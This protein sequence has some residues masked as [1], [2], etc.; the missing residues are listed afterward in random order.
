L[1]GSVAGSIV[2]VGLATHQNHFS[3]LGLNETRAEFCDEFGIERVR[4]I[5]TH[6]IGKAERCAFLVIEYNRPSLRV[7]KCLN[8]VI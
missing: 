8:L 4:L 6:R 2:Q 1:L 7:L 5:S 3:Q